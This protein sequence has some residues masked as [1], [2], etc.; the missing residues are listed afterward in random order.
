MS[1]S[2]YLTAIYAFNY[3]GPARVKL[4]L[5]YF[6]SAGKIWKSSKE[7]LIETGL[8]EKKVSEFSE[9]RKSFDIENYFLRLSKLNIKVVTILDK[10]SFPNS[11]K[12]FPKNLKGLDGA[13]L[14]LY[15]KGDITCLKTN[16]VAI[17]GTRKMT[18]YGRE[19]TQKFSS[20]LA[21]FGITIISGLAYGVDTAAHRACLSVGG[22][23]VAVL[24][25]GLDT[26]YPP[27][28]TVL[29]AEI[30]KTGGA[31]ISEYPLG[32]P[33]LPVNFAIRNRIVSG[34]SSAVIVVEGAEK[35]GTLLTAAHAAEQGKTVFAVPGQITS[36][37]SFAPLF[38][39]KNGA[40]IAT[41]T[42]DI[43]DELDM[44]VKVDKEK[45]QKII[46]DTPEEEKVLAILENEALHL[47]ELVRISGCTTSEI[48]ARL[49]IMEMKGMVRNM[50]QG[51]Y[52]KCN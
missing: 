34:L 50:G 16:C 31:V 5:S 51:M 11:D 29:A 36:P 19:V 52:K 20:E 38:L 27:A 26:I 46:P 33:A 39:L 13:P 7:E 49:T 3:F 43:L 47:D 4:L 32:Y 42:K 25:N 44:Q 1:E 10:K 35:S 17:V 23:T 30:V 37:L 41:E 40:K 14:V 22:K 21:N 48:S 8:S 6:K 18:S 15:Y 24:G 2:E 28:N 12:T 9:F 45:I